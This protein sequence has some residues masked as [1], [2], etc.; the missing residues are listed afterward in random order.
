VVWHRANLMSKADVHNVAELVNY[1][2]RR[3]LMDVDD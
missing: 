1:A 3:G 2:Y